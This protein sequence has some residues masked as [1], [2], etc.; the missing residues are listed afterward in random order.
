MSVGHSVCHNSGMGQ[1]GKGHEQ[2]VN[3]LGLELYQA[4]VRLE[5]GL[6]EFSLV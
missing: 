5:F 6:V 1:E 3:Q 4:K 2:F